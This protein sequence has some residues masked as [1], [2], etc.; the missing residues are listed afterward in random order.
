MQATGA[1]EELEDAWHGEL[2]DVDVLHKY[3]QYNFGGE[4]AYVRQCHS[5]RVA[6]GSHVQSANG[7]D[8][9]SHMYCAMG[10]EKQHKFQQVILGRLKPC[11]PTSKPL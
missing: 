10:L 9:I 7:Q 8:E 3:D 11:M 6:F 1:W 4:P 5:V 2:K